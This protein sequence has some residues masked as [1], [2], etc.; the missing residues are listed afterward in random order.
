MEY[1][2]S[3]PPFSRSF[4]DDLL[5][6]TDTDTLDFLEAMLREGASNWGGV[7]DF[8]ILDV[9]GEPAATCAVFAPDRSVL[10]GP[11]NL[12]RLN[13][14]STALSWRSDVAADFRAAYKRVWDGGADFLEP[15]ADLIVETV[16]VAPHFRGR[17]LGEALM[18]AAFDKARKRRAAS[19]GIMVVH[20]NDAAKALYE[21]H[22]EPY[23]TF[24]AAYF[25]HTF[26]GLTKFRA[27]LS[28]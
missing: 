1:E 20:G 25:D 24:H 27:T 21:K 7:E 6:D 8:I 23:V 10:E 19:V 3:L 22:F 11:L 12:R 26:P 13:R 4:W 2:A 28:D 16:A 15:Q 18:Q 5:R 9:E 17:G 14:V